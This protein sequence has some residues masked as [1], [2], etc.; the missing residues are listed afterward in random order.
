VGLVEKYPLH[1]EDIN[2]IARQATVRSIMR[3]GS[4]KPDMQSIREVL[5][6]YRKKVAPVLFG[7]QSG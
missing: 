3:S 5:V 7:K 1:V 6:S 4:K 2:Y